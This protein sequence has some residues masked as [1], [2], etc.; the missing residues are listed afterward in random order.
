MRN[1]LAP[2]DFAV[3]QKILPL[4]NG[5]GSEYDSLISSLEKEFEGS[6]PLS[7]DVIQKLKR[8]AE[9]N[10]GDYQLF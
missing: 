9:N 2:L 6:M 10:F 8:N 1:V 3:A 4:I 5:S 7:F